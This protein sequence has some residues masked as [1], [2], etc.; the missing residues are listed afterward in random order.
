VKTALKAALA[1][2]GIF[3]FL[4]TL[5]FRPTVFTAVGS[6]DVLAIS[7]LAS[8]LITIAVM[9]LWSLSV[10][11]LNRH[12]PHLG[13]LLIT[14]AAVALPA[15]TLLL[16]TI[17][18]IGFAAVS[19]AFAQVMPLC[20]SICLG[21][22]AI[23][24]IHV[25]THDS[26]LDSQSLLLASG[27]GIMGA[28]LL[29]QLLFSSVSV[30][31][32]GVLTITAL[33]TVTGF[34]LVRSRIPATTL[35][36]DTG[37][38]AL[39]KAPTESIQSLKTIAPVA[40]PVILESLLCTISLGLSWEVEPFS[41][42]DANPG[43]FLLTLALGTGSLFLLYHYWKWRMDI[44]ALLTGAAVP[45]ALPIII[46]AIDGWAAPSFVFMLALLSEL[47]FL[48]LAW[49]GALML[50]RVSSTTEAI[51]PSFVVVFLILYGCFMLSS[52]FLEAQAIQGILA[53]AALCILFYL[54]FFFVRKSYRQLHFDDSQHH[55]TATEID[56]ALRRR[57]AD[58]AAQAHLSPR[59]SELLPLLAIGLTSTTIG[60][61]VFISS[62]TV[63][64][65]RYRIYE[66]IGVHNHD[67]L[68]DT[69]GLMKKDP[70]PK[71]DRAG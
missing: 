70:E 27:L 22:A 12:V 63:K 40:L 28:M 26:T 50:G 57:C 36:R 41:L 58:L 48:L 37:S 43:L 71:E 23:A 55:D 39:D 3:S 9:A 7:P 53:L 35:S 30:S 42:L 59:E 69:L 47:L 29:S 33:L 52:Q 13:H 16:L 5:L 2:T 11:L 6:G 32:F 51:A 64:T 56:E 24:Q 66:K 1:L 8:T 14:I 15:L 49:V 60:R 62:Q 17:L 44:D 10:S 31:A 25:F 4:E 46:S 38:E 19:L 65:H 18:L 67:E 54:I 21:I 68:V 61:R 45:L 34:I 20:A